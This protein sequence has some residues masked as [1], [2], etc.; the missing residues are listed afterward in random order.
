MDSFL[1]FK[2]K[3]GIFQFVIFRIKTLKIVKENSFK[4]PRVQ[5]G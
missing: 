2:I 1:N 4:D 3:N 5:G